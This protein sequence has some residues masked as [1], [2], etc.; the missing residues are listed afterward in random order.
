MPALLR[1]A[2]G[3]FGLTDH[4]KVFAPDP[5]ADIYAL[6][7]IDRARGGLVVVR[8]DQYVAHVLALEDHA[9]LAE[10]FAGFMR[11]AG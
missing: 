1:P 4:E 11:P 6:R 8:P 9:P 7:G 3:R 5:Q 10:F 2:K